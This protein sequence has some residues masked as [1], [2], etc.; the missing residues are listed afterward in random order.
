MTRRHPLILRL[1]C[2]ALSACTAVTP[3]G[4]EQPAT[5]TPEIFIALDP[6]P[7]ASDSTLPLTCQI[8]DLNIYV[9]RAAGYCFAYPRHFSL[10]D[11]PSDWP[12]VVGPV[13][14]D[15]IE[16]IRA[17]F[18][19]EVAKFDLYRSLTEQAEEFL[20]DFTAADPA[21]LTWDPVSLAGD[22][23]VRVE[24]VPARL[25]WRIVFVQRDESLYRLMYWPVD[26]PEAGPDLEE[27]YQVT[28]NTFAF[29]RN[30]N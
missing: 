28:L 3:A 18:F 22:T 2:L 20:R 6:S 19:V 14:D 5:P 25:S 1:A 12:A 23:G 24:P 7:T 10:G 16:P 15:S 9:D 21:G 4:I 17:T 13:L 11:Q 30:G 8:T 26:V 27:L 29:I